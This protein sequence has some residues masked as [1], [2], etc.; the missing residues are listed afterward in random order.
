[1]KKIETLYQHGTLAQLVSGLFE[2]NLSIGELLEHGDTGIGTLSGLDGELMIIKG[3]VYQFAANGKI[4]LVNSDE[5]VPFANIHFQND[6]SIGTLANLDFATFKN[7][8]P[9]KIK[10]LNLFFAVR[11]VGLFDQIHTRAIA[12]QKPPYPTLT[13]AAAKQKEYLTTD[14]RGTA[15]GYFCPDL[16]SGTGTPG[17]HL[18]FLAENQQ[19]GGHLLDFKLNSG[20]LFIQV[21]TD[22]NLH[23]PIEDPLF[24]KK[25]FKLQNLLNSIIKAEG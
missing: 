19:T 13:D 11:L 18:H 9:Q 12:A 6:Q 22:F 20:E 8:I 15:I 5:K 17:F 7:R 16:Y 14:I 21:F 25:K 23:L 10:T 24:L 1:M 4:R 3:K 2:G